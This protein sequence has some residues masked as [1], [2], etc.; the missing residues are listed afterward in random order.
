M[1]FKTRKIEFVQD[2]LELQVE[3]LIILFE[4]IL[5]SYSPKQNKI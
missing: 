3:E 1:D 2:F 4:K 5:Q